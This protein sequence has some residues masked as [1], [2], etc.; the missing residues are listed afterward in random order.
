MK[1]PLQQQYLSKTQKYKFFK[2]P[3]S[4]SNNIKYDDHKNCST[5]NKK[6]NPNN[7][8]ISRN[9]FIK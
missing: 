2:S 7:N 8:N 3:T 4:K 1:S 6:S 5:S 9:L